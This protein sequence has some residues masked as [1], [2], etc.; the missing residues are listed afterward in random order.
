MVLVVSAVSVRLIDG[1]SPD[2]AEFRE[3]ADTDGFA[4][5]DFSAA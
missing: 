5:F 3:S 4:L 1:F 2:L